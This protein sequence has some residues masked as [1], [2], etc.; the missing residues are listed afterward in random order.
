MG[1]HGT[2]PPLRAPMGESDSLYKS[3]FVLQAQV[4]YTIVSCTQV[5]CTSPFVLFKVDL[6]RNRF[7]PFTAVIGE[8]FSFFF[9]S[10]TSGSAAVILAE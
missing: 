10:A 5:S 6:H 8:F 7:F 2:V 3:F 9:F 1:G 4:S